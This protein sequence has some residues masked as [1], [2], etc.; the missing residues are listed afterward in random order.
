MAPGPVPAHAMKKSSCLL[1][2]SFAL[3]LG[4]AVGSSLS[5]RFYDHWINRF[6]THDA[7]VGA[8]DRLAALHALRTGDTNQVAECL[9]VQLD[10]QIMALG[11]ML[12]NVPVASRPA[13]AVRLLARLRDYRAVHPRKTGRPEFD[14]GVAAVLSL[15]GPNGQP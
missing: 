6:Q 12:R 5:D 1:F 14:N 10:S 11:A 2:V 13:E 4:W 9:E 3:L 7:V 8:G 15:A